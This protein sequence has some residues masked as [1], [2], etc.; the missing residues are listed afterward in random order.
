M[1][2]VWTH[3]HFGEKLLEKTGIIGLD[4]ETGPYFRFGTQGP[5]PFFYHNFWPWKSTPVAKVGDRI[6]TNNVGH[7]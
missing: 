7:F 5:D 3:I 1:P 6:L 2:N 4:H